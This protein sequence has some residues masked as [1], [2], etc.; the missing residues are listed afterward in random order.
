[1]LTW[2]K[3]SIHHPTGEHFIQKVSITFNDKEQCNI[4]YLCERHL[5]KDRDTL[6][7]TEKKQQQA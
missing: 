7:N 6:N 1:M 5:T 4:H 2:K 3:N